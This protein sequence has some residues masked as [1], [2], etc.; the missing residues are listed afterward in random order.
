MKKNYLTVADYRRIC[1]GFFSKSNRRGFGDQRYSTYHG[2][3]IVTCNRA[4][5]NGHEICFVAYCPTTEGDDV[6]CLGS[7]NSRRPAREKARQNPQLKKEINSEN[8]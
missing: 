3:L 4:L 7:F 6:R 8:P 2:C 5:S 1:P